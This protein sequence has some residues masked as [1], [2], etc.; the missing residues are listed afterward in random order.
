[1][2]KDSESRLI[3]ND[4]NNDKVVLK[5]QTVNAVKTIVSKIPVII[6]I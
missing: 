1:M 4:N 3:T 2:N 6:S 5:D